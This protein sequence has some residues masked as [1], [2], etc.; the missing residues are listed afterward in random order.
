VFFFSQSH[1][2]KLYLRSSI[3]WAAIKNALSDEVST[4]PYCAAQ[5]SSTTKVLDN[6]A[7]FSAS[8][9]SW[10]R[11][12]GRIDTNFPRRGVWAGDL[13]T[14]RN[15]QFY[16][17]NLQFWRPNWRL[18][19]PSEFR[20]DL[21]HHKTKSPLTIVRRCFWDPR[22]SRFDTTPAC[23]GQTDGQQNDDSIY[24]TSIA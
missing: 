4:G 19:I 13:S 5:T 3:V 16:P 18:S 8:A 2:Y 15:T 23:G 9:P 1:F 11:T 21:S 24:R 20:R 12:T 14:G 10:T 6:T 22:F 7:Y 17:P